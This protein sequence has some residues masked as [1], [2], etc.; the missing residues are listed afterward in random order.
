MDLIQSSA[1]DRITLMI[2]HRMSLAFRAD[3]V[4]VMGPEGVEGL[5]QPIRLYETC[6]LFK[7]MCLAQHVHP[8]AV[9]RFAAGRNA[10]DL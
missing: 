1:A 4:L 10:D 7:Y 5:G 3:T 2:T 9:A 6:P 8:D